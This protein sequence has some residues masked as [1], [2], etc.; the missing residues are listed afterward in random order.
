MGMIK[1]VLGL[2][3]L[4]GMSVVVVIWLN[5]GAQFVGTV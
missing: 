2:A 4:M 3:T 5:A 1:D